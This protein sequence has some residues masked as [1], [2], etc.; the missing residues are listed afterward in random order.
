VHLA[1]GAGGAGTVVKRAH[2]RLDATARGYDG[3]HNAL[4]RRVAPTVNAGH[5]ACW[6]C[7]QVIIPDTSWDLGHDDHNRSIYRGPEHRRC[8]RSAAAKKHWQMY[9]AAKRRQPHTAIRQIATRQKPAK[10]LSFFD[11]PRTRR[12]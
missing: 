2:N 11:P 12:K 3:A 1:R 7:R 10:A 4:R 8:N 5:A 9:W 6:R